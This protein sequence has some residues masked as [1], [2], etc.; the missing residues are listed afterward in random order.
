[1]KANQNNAAVQEKLEAML[2]E[3]SDLEEISR[4]AAQVVTLD[5]TRVGRLSR[6][7][8]MQAQAVSIEANRRRALHIRRIH[9]ALARIASGDYGWCTGCGE[10]INPGR[11]EID[12]AADLCIDCAELATG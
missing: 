3:L 12:P 2:A 7:D 8:A 9:A 5:Q 11:L 6:M 4:Q 10:S 1:M